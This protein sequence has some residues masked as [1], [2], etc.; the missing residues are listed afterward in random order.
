MI[1]KAHSEQLVGEL[2]RAGHESVRFVLVPGAGHL[3]L[4]EKPDEVTATLTELFRRVAA[5]E[6]VRPA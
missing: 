3:V 6:T 2:E 4:L 5:E 1:P